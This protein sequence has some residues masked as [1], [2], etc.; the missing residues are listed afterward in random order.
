MS[1]SSTIDP[2]TIDWLTLDEDEEIV[3]SGNPHKSS[4]IPAIVIGVPLS[5]LL[6]GLFIIAGAYL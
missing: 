1:E 6:V 2:A 5:L 4:L 3:W